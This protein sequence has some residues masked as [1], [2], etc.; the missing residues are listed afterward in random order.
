ML[1]LSIAGEN[2]VFILGQGDLRPSQEW[3]GNK[4]K[5]IK[6]RKDILSSLLSVMEHE[7]KD[8][9]SGEGTPIQSPD[10]IRLPETEHLTK[11]PAPERT[12][13]FKLMLPHRD[14]LIP[15]AG[16]VLDLAKECYLDGLKWCS[17][18]KRKRTRELA[19]DGPDHRKGWC[20]VCS[21]S[22]RE[23]AEQFSVRRV[24]MLP[25]SL[26]VDHE[27]C[28]IGGDPLFSAPMTLS[29]LVMSR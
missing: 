29:S 14:S 1:F 6:D 23:E 18:K 11:S 25:K 24:F 5:H 21:N 15:K 16:D 17:S 4:W 13:E 28:K 12:V 2:K 9:F 20:E 27:N 3:I 26:K 22:S 8:S 19:R 10:T 7:N